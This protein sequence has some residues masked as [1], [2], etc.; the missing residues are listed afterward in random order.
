MI[1]IKHSTQ[2]WVYK[3]QRTSNEMALEKIIIIL[4]FILLF[5]YYYLIIII[6]C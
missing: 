3:L 4:L 6:L 2:Q 1:F 5:Y